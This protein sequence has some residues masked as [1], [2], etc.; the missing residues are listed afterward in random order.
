MMTVVAYPLALNRRAGVVVLPNED[1]RALT[2][3]LRRHLLASERGA[4]SLY[5]A[6]FGVQAVAE[7][8]AEEVH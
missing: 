7:P 1:A 5:L 2:G 4:G 8:V 3:S 6:L